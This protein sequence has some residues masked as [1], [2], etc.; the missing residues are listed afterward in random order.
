M[1][2]DQVVAALMPHAQPIKGFFKTAMRRYKEEYEPSARADHDVSIQAQCLH[3]HIIKEA[4]TYAAAFPDSEVKLGN[5]NG[6]KHLL[7]NGNIALRFK[8][9][10][11]ELQ[12][13]NNETAQSIAYRCG[14]SMAGIEADVRLDAGYRLN[15]AGDEIQSVHI[16]RW[17]SPR[18]TQWHFELL[19][20]EIKS[21]VIPLFPVPEEYPDEPPAEIRGKP[22]NV[23]ELKPTENDH[24]E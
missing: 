22:S 11:C 2:E 13:S 3:G 18:R 21:A 15:S 12:P 7:V 19:D 24:D 17:C 14:A 9:V 6:L 4:S 16:I 8:K 10:D 23:V 20:D 5:S 1:T